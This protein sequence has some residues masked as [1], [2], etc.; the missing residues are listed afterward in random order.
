MSS[1]DPAQGAFN[2]AI[3]EFKTGLNNPTLYSQIL[4]TTSIDQ[5]YDLTDQL[6]RTQGRTG[7]LTN[8]SRIGVFLQRMNTYAGV[9]ETFVQAKPDILALIWGPIKLLI[10][11][12]SN[13]TKSLDALIGMTEKLGVLLPEFDHAAKLFGNKRHINQVL[14]LLFQDMLD[15]YLASLKFF[16]MKGLKPFFEALWPKKKEE[17]EQVIGRLE[18]HTSYLRNEVRLQDIQEAY[19]ARQFAIKSFAKLEESDRRQEY[20]ALETAIRPVFHDEKLDHVLTRVCDGTGDWLIKDEDIKRWF[21]ATPGSGKIIWIC[22][23]PGAGKTYLSAY[24]IKEARKHGNTVF[25]FLSHEQ[26]NISATSVIISFIFQLARDN[27]TLQDMVRQIS[28]DTLERNLP[29]AVDFF[30]KLIEGAGGAFIVIDGLDE[31]QELERVSLL[32]QMLKVTAGCDGARLLIASRLESD[33]RGVLEKGSRSIRVDTLNTDSIHLFTKSR[34]QDWLKGRSF[35]RQDSDEIT[36][37]IGGVAHK[38]EG[39]F[40]YAHLVLKGLDFLH[41]VAEIRQDL[42]I[43]PTDLNAAYERIFDRIN[44]NLPNRASRE[45]ARKALGWIGCSPVPLTIRELEQALVVKVGNLDQDLRGISGL[46]LDHLCGPIVEEIDGKLHLIHFTAK[47]YFFSPTIEN[48]LD[49]SQCILSLV[50]CCITYLCQHHH[51][52]IDPELFRQNVIDGIYRLHHFASDNWSHLVL[53]YLRTTLKP[54]KEEGL[55]S[56]VA[57]I[58]LL[59]ARANTGF[60]QSDNRIEQSALKPLQTPEDQSVYNLVC[61]ELQFHTEASTRLFEIGTG[62]LTSQFA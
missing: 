1:P 14:A 57:L 36:A 60:S 11:L 27:P 23:I 41:S 46:K 54:R 13:F 48:H 56:L 30:I 42:N 8:L 52:K 9:I 58:S 29:A 47:E 6:Q 28:R 55:I 17:I 50:K 31:F 34:C 18:D 62:K 26:K 44:N 16:G 15:F 35:N 22:G 2:K 3:R 43:L 59:E 61:N 40:L 53:T 4:A 49:P 24:T 37:L 19:E 32:R 33:I 5:V 38:A 51:D 7:C 10:L 12:T 25:A 20:A 39:M 45:K 21:K